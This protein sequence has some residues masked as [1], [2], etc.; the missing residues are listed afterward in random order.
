M[1]QPTG[2]GAGASW[3]GAVERLFA[4]WRDS[5]QQ[6]REFDAAGPEEIERM[7]REFGMSASDLAD[8]AVRGPS[9]A[10]LLYQRMSALGLSAA[11][12]ERIGHGVLWDLERTC[13]CCGSKKVCGRDL[14]ERPA[15]AKWQDY[16]P[17]VLTLES[18]RKTKGRFPA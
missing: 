9:A 4:R 14:A 15:D 5:L 6:R 7:A 13:S 2:S 10:D 8:L 17:N 3:V 11:D 18:V 16:C 1:S 12:V